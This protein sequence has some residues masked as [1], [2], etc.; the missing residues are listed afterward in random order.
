MHCI[1]YSYTGNSTENV[2]DIMSILTQ[3][4][5]V[6]DDQQED[7]FEQAAARA[8]SKENEKNA[9]YSKPSN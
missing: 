7:P 6:H 8:S 3:S 1:V 2:G 4:K 9:Y 5:G